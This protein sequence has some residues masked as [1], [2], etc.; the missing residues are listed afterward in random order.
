MMRPRSGWEI[1][2]PPHWQR[3]NGFELSAARQAVAGWTPAQRGRAVLAAHAR[4]VAAAE[5]SAGDWRSSF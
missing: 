1:S 2:Y 3:Y 4:T 5:F